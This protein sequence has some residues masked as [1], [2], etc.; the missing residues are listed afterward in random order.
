MLRRLTPVLLT[1]LVVVLGVTALAARPPHGNPGR[2]AD[3]VVL[4]GA[5]GLRWDDVDPQ[6][7]P[8][9]WRMAEQGS[10]GSLSVRSAH[11]PT[12]PVD[13]WLTLGAGNF[14]AWNGS[15]S[16]AGC[17]ATGV[18]VEQ[19]DG[20]GANLPDQE[21]VVAYNQDKL[22]W[23]ATPGA[24]SES[25]R[26]S[27]AVGPGAAVAAARPFGRVDR[28]EPVLPADPAQLLGSCVLSIVD[29]GSV[30]GENPATRAAQ[31]RQ[32][33]A[34][35]ARV[36]AARPARSTVLV[37]G[38][39]DT[40]PP[41]RLHVAVADGPGWERGWLTSPSTGREGYLQLVDLAPTALVVLG[42]PVPERLFLGR[43]AVSVGDRP[44]DLRTAID[45]PADAD[46]E[47]AAQRRV[48]GWFFG[49]L[50]A[51]QVALAVAVLPLLRRARRHAGPH[52]PEP[53]SRR[54]V[55][56]VELLLIA[57]AL[58][59]PAAL[60]ADAAPWWRGE[61]AGW[62]FA[63]VTA[64]LIVG[65]TA[66]VRF[67]PGHDRTLGPL[68]AVAGLATLVVGVDVLTGSRLQL[69]GVVG[70]SALEGGRY[71]GLG[72]VG[73]GVFIAGSLLCGG[74]LAQRVRRAWRPMVMVA[75]GGAAVVIVGSPY[76]GADSIGAIALTAGVSVAAAIC[77]GGWLT[78]S[79]LA[80]ATMAGLALTIGYAVVDLRR[81]AVERGSVG[82]F[83]AALGDGTGGLTVHRSSAANLQTLVD[84]PLTVLALAGAALVWLALLQPWGGLMR[85]F[86]IYPAVRAA[87]AGTG[88]AAGVGGL[89]G[90]SALDV[91]GAAGAL[92]VPMAALAA[93]RVLDHSTDRTQP[94]TD[95]P[96]DE[97]GTW[98][99]RPGDGDGGHPPRSADP[100]ARPAADAAGPSDDSGPDDGTGARAQARP[101]RVPAPARR[102]STELPTA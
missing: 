84:S 18:T 25:V 16:A 33:D 27:V 49:L 60:L 68:G 13:G 3:F 87:M 52:G 62:W 21:S 58:A 100:G 73:L 34:Q 95:R 72:T 37:A 97:S 32:V 94:G 29:L 12:C 56:A 15:R 1:L 101:V 79:R 36:L 31:A 10:I 30:D 48:A 91:A 63:L 61:H 24:L 88:V 57:A 46:R 99:A 78:V 65:G 71:T 90:G 35:L 20:I 6:T 75:V 102:A 82:R 26:C 80:W 2:S 8:T 92:V 50:A 76:L 7:T 86:G 28:Y 70:Y 11:R 40:D 89:L 53:V 17:P 98:L 51:A 38:V 64:L 67:S 66:A 23:G 85:L 96:G 54:V 14:A 42:R 5:A 4:A 43:A 39:G 93:L 55:A 83:L 81:P 74:W 22:T 77:T 59:V 45:A 19:P 69:N 47:A 9:L 41:S 44:D